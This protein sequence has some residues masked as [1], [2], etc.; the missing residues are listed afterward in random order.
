MT[1]DKPEWGNVYMRPLLGSSYTMFSVRSV[2][3]LY[4]EDEREEVAET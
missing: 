4:S 2:S 1:T 3:R